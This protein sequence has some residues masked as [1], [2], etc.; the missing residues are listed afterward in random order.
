VENGYTDYAILY[1][2][3]A[4]EPSLGSA[5]KSI[6]FAEEIRKLSAALGIPTDLK[7]FGVKTEDDAKLIID[8]SMQLKAAFDQNPVPFG[9]DEIEKL[10]Y[11]LR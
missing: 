9:R 6:R 3:I 2:L 10:I 4:N 5:E 1:D 7:G 11:S 8:N